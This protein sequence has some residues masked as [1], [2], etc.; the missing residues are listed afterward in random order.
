MSKQVLIEKEILHYP[1]NEL[2]YVSKLYQTKFAAAMSEHAYYKA[3][4]R[5]STSNFVI[6]MAKG[7]YC[8]PKITKYGAVLPSEREIIKLFTEKN[9]GTVVGYS[10]YNSLNLT[11]Q[12]AKKHEVYSSS[13][14]QQT[15]TI[16]NVFI[17]QY[18]LE[19]SE[20]VTNTIHMMEVLQHYNEIQN[21][22]TQHFINLCKKFKNQYS[23]EVFEY[24]IKHIRYSK[25]TISFLKNILDYYHISNSLGRYLS[26]FSEYNHPRM[27]TI[28]EP[29][30]IH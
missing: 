25:R 18:A 28:Y 7:I 19:Y 10:L 23:E 12:I 17:K 1:V 22:N 9:K 3:V 11:T 24:V 30:Q 21:L 8:R 15:K 29:A 6:K 26:V 5:L 20:R 2:I 13:V 14:E 27:E 4:E 16:G